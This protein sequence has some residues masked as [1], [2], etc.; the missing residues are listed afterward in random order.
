MKS[1]YR[2]A[3][4]STCLALLN[5]TDAFVKVLRFNSDLKAALRVIVHQPLP[6]SFDRHREFSSSAKTYPTI[7]RGNG[8][9]PP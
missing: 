9:S 1:E 6:L 2:T 3:E 7:G 4:N 5:F 8:P